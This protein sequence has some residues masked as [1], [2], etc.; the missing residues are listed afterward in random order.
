VSPFSQPGLA[1]AVPEPVLER[2]R[3]LEQV[4]QGLVLSVPV[5]MPMPQAVFLRSLP[6]SLIRYV[7]SLRFHGYLC[8]FVAHYDLLSDILP[9]NHLSEDRIV[10]IVQMRCGLIYNDVELRSGGVTSG[11]RHSDCSPVVP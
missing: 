2:V 10:S 4:V 9:G 5:Q 11:I 8:H 6:L 1:L 7:V 3:V